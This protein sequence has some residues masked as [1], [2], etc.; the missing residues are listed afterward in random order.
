MSPFCSVK[1]GTQDVAKLEEW[2]DNC[3]Q[4]TKS[5]EDGRNKLRDLGKSEGANIEEQ[6]QQFEVTHFI[7]ILYRV[8]DYQIKEYR[9]L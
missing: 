9:V 3:Q 4:L 5:V 2:R 6:N 1:S 8:F 7:I